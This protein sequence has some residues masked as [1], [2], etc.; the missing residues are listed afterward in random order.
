LALAVTLVALVAGLAAGDGPA[1]A[2]RYGKAVQVNASEFH[3]LLSRSRLSPG[4]IRVELN[5][6]GEDPH[7]LVVRSTTRKAVYRWDDVAPG[8]A[9][10]RF[11]K[12]RPGRWNLICAL[13]GH[14]DLG[15]ISKFRVRRR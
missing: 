4:T 1:A 15:M 3:F 7:N 6:R 9:V 5:N 11:I 8:E 10:A 13:P 14:K 12:L 2:S